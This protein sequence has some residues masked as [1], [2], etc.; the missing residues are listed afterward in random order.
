MAID[1]ALL[2]SVAEG[3][4]Q[5]V[6]RLY[7]WNPFCLSLGYA[8][9]FADADPVALAEQ[10]WGLVRRPTGGRAILHGDE[11][12]Y[13]VIGKATNR[14][15]SGGVL[16]SYQH[17]SQGLVQALKTLGLSPAVT[18]D[19]AS[20]DKTQRANPICFEVPSAYEITANGKKLIGSAQ[21]RRLGAVLQHGTLPL[22]GDITRVCQVLAFAS[23]SDRL[24]ASTALSQRA[25]TLSHVLGREVKWQEAAEGL[26]TG[27]STGLGL[28]LEMDEL[29]A[30][31]KTRAAELASQLYSQAEWTRRV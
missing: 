24:S 19:S 28:I 6:L 2:E 7:R 23:E 3:H 4:S 25:T 29:T 20:L 18:P 8:Q 15:L 30:D 13:A 5:P 22:E 12:T 14:H 10:G 21:T 9:P 27:F 17:L 16:E 1:H 26:I 11:L 31:E